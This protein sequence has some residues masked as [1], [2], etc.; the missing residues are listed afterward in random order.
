MQIQI[1]TREAVL[2]V[3][4]RFDTVDKN[5]PVKEREMELQELRLRQQDP[6]LW[7]D[8]KRAVEITR[9]VSEAERFLSEYYALKESV[10]MCELWILEDEPDAEDFSSAYSIPHRIICC[11]AAYQASDRIDVHRHPMPEV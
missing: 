2:D 7:D 3:R 11:Y 1:P 4:Q 6:A 10:E 8:Q 9:K 5:V